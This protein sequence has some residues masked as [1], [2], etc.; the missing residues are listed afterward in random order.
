M[1]NART[2]LINWVLARQNGWRVL[3]RMDDLEGPRI[4]TGADVEAIEDLQWLGLHWEEPIIRQ[5]QR[6]A[7]Y[8]DALPTLIDGGHVY[9]C[10]CTR[11]EIAA[12]AGGRVEADQSVFY[13]GTCRGRFTTAAEA[14]R[15]TGRPAALRFKVPDREL[16]L[17]DGFLGRQSAAGQRD[18][19]D[20]VVQKSDGE[21]GY[22]LANVVDDAWAGI[23]HVVR[24]Q[25]LLA[26][27][28]RQML[29]YEAL[30]LAAKIPAYTH[31]PLVV[32]RDGLKLAKRHGDTR[33]R[34]LREEGVAAG[35]IRR[36]LAIWSGWTPARSE[37]SI[38]EWIDRFHLQGLPHEPVY[39]DDASKR[40]TVRQGQGPA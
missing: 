19:G 8:E 28:P 12:A 20:F 38:D 7:A 30:G 3:L 16:A 2:F 32:G 13:P 11:S 37:A 29:V 25:D 35:Q 5:S 17:Q 27:A 9:P 21:F 24:G 6:T 40:P 34:Q 4:K 14:Q 36:L 22:H 31:L 26:S 1:G 10:V 23:T 15:A 18:L 39:Y 33:L